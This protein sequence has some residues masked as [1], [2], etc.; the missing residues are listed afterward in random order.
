MFLLLE[1]SGGLNHYDSWIHFK[2]RLDNF[3][4]NCQYLQRNTHKSVSGQE[5]RKHS[6]NCKEKR[7]NT[8]FDHKDIRKN[9]RTKEDYG[10]GIRSHYWSSWL[11]PP[12]KI[13]RA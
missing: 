11:Y 7:L 9:G 4:L 2:E 10:K 13:H 5:N 1:K 3:I 8:G 12:K 6:W